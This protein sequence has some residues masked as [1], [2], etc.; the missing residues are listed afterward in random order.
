M[1]ELI[2]IVEDEL[3]L[4]E[5]LA[6]NLK[7]EGFQVETVADGIQALDAA[8]EHT[9][10]LIVLDIMLPGID[11]LEVTR[12][13]RK[14]SN[15]PVLMLTARDDE[16]DRVLGLELGADDYMTKPFSMREL[17]ARVKALLR[18]V[19]LDRTEEHEDQVKQANILRF[20]DLTINTT[21]HEVLVGDEVISLRPKEYD[22]LLFLAR[23]QGQVLSR[24]L[25]LERVWGWDFS[26]NTR[27]VDVHIRWLRSKIEPN[28][29]EPHRIITVR[30]VGYRFDG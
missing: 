15:T 11:G 5:S 20:E 7:K 29:D 6:F 9:P 24:S 22:L 8:R 13:L 27:T 18:R 25:I 12:L 23:N 26:G 14:D 17:I 30:G 28:A 1:A 4:R 19:R 10:D 16:I 21:R 2:L 3:A